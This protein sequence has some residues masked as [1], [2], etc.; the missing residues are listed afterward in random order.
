MFPSNKEETMPTLTER[1]ASHIR[2]ILSC[3]DRVIIQGTLPGLCYAEGMTGFLYARNIRI[4]D[5]PRFAEPL[6]DQI[7]A[8]AETLAQ[9]HGLEIEFIRRID[10]VRKEDRI[11]EIL[12]GRGHHPGL[13]HIFSAMETC[14]SYKPWH[15]K[16]THKTFLKPDSGKCLH[17]YFYF[18]DAQFGLCYLRVPTWCP[19]RLQFY[20]NGHNLLASELKRKGIAYE[21]IDNAFTKIADFTQAQKLADTFRVETLHKALDRFASLYCPVL[22]TLDLT[23]HWSLMQVEYATDIIF[24]KAEDLSTLYEPLTRTAIHAVKADNVATFLGRKLTGHYEGEAGNDFHTRIEGTRLKHHMGPVSLKMYDKLGFILRIETT[25]NDVSFFK[26]YRQ[27]EQRD[28]QKSFKLAPLK[29]SIYSLQPDLRDLLSAA[30]QRY[31]AFLSDLDDPSVEIKTLEKI[32]EPLQEGGRSYSGYNFFRQEDQTLFETIL[33][34]EF[35]ISGLR[36]KNL[37]RLLDKTTSQIS[38][39]LKRLRLHGLIRKIGRSYKYYLTNLGR[40]VATMG[41]KLKELYIIP[42]LARSLA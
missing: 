41:L 23:Y 24:N 2:G 5:Y 21:L 12:K 30:N 35:N 26:H 13:V 11:Q 8:N 28:G 9:K 27:V 42:T 3:Y 14:S 4:F 16:Q 33:R 40:R 29:K 36:N 31:L 32:S 1:Y 17:Y 39:A 19:F 38:Y 10:S 15:D 25:A 37:R 6:R 7:R 18:I 20:F 34:G 22:K